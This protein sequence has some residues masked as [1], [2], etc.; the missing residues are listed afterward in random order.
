MSGLQKRLFFLLMSSL[1]ACG[2][3]LVEFGGT[4]NATNPPP[5]VIS[6]IPANAATGVAINQ[7]IS[8]TFST[9]MNPSTITAT[10]FTVKQGSTAVA[11]TVNYVGT[12]ATFAPTANL[13]ANTTFGATITAGVKD[14]AGTA[15][16]ADY[17]WSFTTGTTVDSTAPT[18]TSTDP[19]DKATVVGLDKKV[20]A[21][22]S[23]AMDPL[24][25]TGTTFTLAT[26]STA[27]GC[28]TPTTP[29]TGAV[30]YAGANVTATFAPQSNLAA[31]TTYR[32]TV[33]TG[34]KDL[35]G[36]A[37]AA[38]YTWTFTTGAPAPPPPL[39][40]NLGRAA[41]YGLASRAGLTSTGVT[42]VNGNIALY[43]TATCT[44]STGNAGASQTCLVQVY[45]SP[46]GMTVN[47]KIYWAGDPF[48]NGSTANAVTNDLNSAWVEGKNKVPNQPTIAGNQLSSPTP[49][50][51]GIYHNPTLG[52][53]AGGTATLD[54]AGDA[55]AVWIFQD[56]ASFVDS[57][58]LLLP[59]KIVLINGA[60]AKN[61]WFI[62]GSD[63][64]MGSGTT[65]NGNVLVGGTVTIKNGST[66]VGRVLGGAAGAGAVTLTG[67]ASPS[68]TTVTVPQ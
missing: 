4:A 33:T 6:T 1:A 16:V 47:G 63:F 11:G 66:S 30:T 44:D 2:T 53:S 12:S 9:A 56:D 23:K 8:A 65:W 48:D 45:S 39:A 32:G 20:S 24:T 59:S 10:T 22:F 64:T 25:I 38:N 46:T 7:K 35:A 28:P 34:A 58:T 17:N 42:V 67:A 5:T 3:Q 50:V 27:P 68:V 43:P 15:M 31:S 55:N 52:M 40:I 60:Q 51:P 26:C 29:V 36:N 14:L 49:Y 61:V 37:L 21:V 13:A 18:V 57:G 62:V 19:A 54:A 41:T